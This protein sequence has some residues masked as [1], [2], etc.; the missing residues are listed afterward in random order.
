MNLTAPQV[1]RLFARSRGWAWVRILAGEFGPAR[2][3]ENRA[4]QPW[5]VTLE[6]VE[7]YAGV[8][9]TPEQIAAA[10]KTRTA[11]GIS[12]IEGAVHGQ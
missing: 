1:A 7:A 9:F 6:A 5:I 12:E 11:H 3:A 10:T 4:G 2:Q 8:T